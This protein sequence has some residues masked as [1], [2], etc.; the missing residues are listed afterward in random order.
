LPLWVIGTAV[1]ILALAAA[2]GLSYLMRPGKNAPED[3]K[4]AA[5]AVMTGRCSCGGRVV[6]DV[7]D[8]RAMAV[9][10]CVNPECGKR[11]MVDIGDEE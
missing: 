6:K 3:L 1:A 9:F 10:N 11:F 4:Q 2:G 5:R 7:M 8:R